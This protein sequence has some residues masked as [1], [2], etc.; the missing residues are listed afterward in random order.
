MGCKKLSLGHAAI[1][2]LLQAAYLQVLRENSRGYLQFPHHLA[3][4][5]FALYRLLRNLY[6]RCVGRDCFAVTRIIKANN[7]VQAH[8]IGFY[9]P[10]I[11][12]SGYLGKH[13]ARTCA[14]LQKYDE[15][16]RIVLVIVFYSLSYWLTS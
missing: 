10:M 2:I 8:I 6:A 15:I 14:S 4:L 7:C 13:F 3:Y 1:S 11:A 9:Y 5:C 16:L 12:S